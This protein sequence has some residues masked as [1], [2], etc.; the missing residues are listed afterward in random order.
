MRRHLELVCKH[1]F[2]LSLDFLQCMEL[3][4][5]YQP[6]S[7][8]V[9]RVLLLIINLHC[10]FVLSSLHFLC[11]KFPYE[12][13]RLLHGHFVMKL[14]IYLKWKSLPK[15]IDFST[16]LEKLD[17]DDVLFVEVV[18]PNSEESPIFLDVVGHSQ[19]HL[20]VL[21]ALKSVNL[22]F[23]VVCYI[24][25]IFIELRQTNELLLVSLSHWIEVVSIYKKVL[26]MVRL[27]DLPMKALPI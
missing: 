7:V 2:H 15:F 27:N 22:I 21:I 1:L 6:H 3:A 16:I 5:G 12:F 25:N 8:T 11:V 13:L 17:F 19:Y 24:L 4:S 18:R 9:S 26:L 10:S 23:G 20:M 14:E